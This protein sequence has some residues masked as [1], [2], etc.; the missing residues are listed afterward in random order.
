VRRATPLATLTMEGVRQSYRL[1]VTCWT[2]CA[3]SL[4]T[5]GTRAARALSGDNEDLWQWCMILVTF[6]DY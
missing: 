1:A 2:R 6:R 5:F 4:V 3:D